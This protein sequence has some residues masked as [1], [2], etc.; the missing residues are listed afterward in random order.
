MATNRY[1][2]KMEWDNWLADWTYKLFDSGKELAEGNREWA[3]KIADHYGIK[4]PELTN[5]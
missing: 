2:L 4:V 3:G 5:D 1:E